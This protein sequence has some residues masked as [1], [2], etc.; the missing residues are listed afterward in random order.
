MRRRTQ[1]DI[2]SMLPLMAPLV[3]GA[4]DGSD[5]KARQRRLVADLCRLIGNH[6]RGDVSQP[7]AN[8]ATPPSL[9]DADGDGISPRMRQTLNCLLTGDSEKQAAAK[10][11][12]SQHT[13]HVY[14]KQ[15]YR[16]FNV[17][18]RGELLARWVRS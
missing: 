12:V 17:N 1:L 6:L 11:G 4:I 7:Q 9:P 3:G 16:K 10:L 15:L 2:S 8:L 14:V 18:S 5:D 13:V